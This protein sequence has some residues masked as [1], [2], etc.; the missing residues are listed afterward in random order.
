MSEVN[1][2]KLVSRSELRSYMNTGTTVAPAFSLIGE[3]FT[4]LSEAKNPQEYSRKYVSERTER[5][6]VV[7]YAPSIS[8][9]VDVYTN[10][11]VIKKIRDVT[12]KEMIGTDAQVEIVVV[13][14]FS[15][16]T[17]NESSLVA[18]KRTYAIIPDAKAD[19]TEA[20]VYTGTFKAVG[21][22]TKGTFDANTKSFTAEEATA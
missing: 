3:G 19:G 1:V 15:D 9:S 22:I 13:E 17:I 18:Y 6:D 16:G 11:P 7:G 21:D 10:N 20:L 2:S 5:T 14:H 4:N 8:Y 12:D